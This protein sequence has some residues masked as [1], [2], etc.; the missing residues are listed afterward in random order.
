MAWLVRRLGPLLATRIS[1]LLVG[2]ETPLDFANKGKLKG[3]SKQR[4]TKA[5]PASAPLRSPSKK[6]TGSPTAGAASSAA[7]EEA[8]A[9]PAPSK[10]TGSASYQEKAVAPLAAVNDQ[11]AQATAK[12]RNDSVEWSVNES[13]KL[14]TSP[15]SKGL[16]SPSPPSPQ[17]EPRHLRFEFEEEALRRIAHGLVTHEARIEGG[18][19]KG[20]SVRRPRRPLPPSAALAAPCHPLPSSPPSPPPA[21]LAA[22]A[23]VFQPLPP[24]PARCR[25]RP[26]PA[27]SPA[28]PTTLAPQAPASLLRVAGAACHAVC[29]LSARGRPGGFFVACSL[30]VSLPCPHRPAITSWPTLQRAR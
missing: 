15:R 13:K 17:P 10:A 1:R 24:P 11:E 20:I 7:Q 12:A 8:A 19:W 3:K 2:E 29:A 27:I 22:L 9:V 16:S 25:P 28:A 14:T 30:T 18:D 4:V 6:S 21:A 5:T 23:A 26:P